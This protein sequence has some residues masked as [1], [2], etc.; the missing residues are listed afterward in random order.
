MSG[1]LLALHDRADEVDVMAAMIEI[2]R[3]GIAQLGLRFIVSSGN[4]YQIGWCHQGLVGEIV[5]ANASPQPFQILYPKSEVRFAFPSID[6]AKEDLAQQV[7]KDLELVERPKFCFREPVSAARDG[8]WVGPCGK[9][10]SCEP[11]L[12]ARLW[13]ALSA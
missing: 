2:A 9:S 1:M 11:R 3:Q 10:P 8:S 12:F 13:K 4:A 5:M 7:M 6:P